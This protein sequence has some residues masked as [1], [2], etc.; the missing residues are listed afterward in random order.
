MRRPAP[1]ENG[2]A[3][4]QGFIGNGQ[5]GPF[6]G[7]SPRPVGLLQ[8]WDAGDDDKPISPRGWLLGNVFC[9]RYVSS[10]IAAGGIGK[11]AVRIAQLLSLASGRSLTGEHVFQQC[12]VLVISLE[13]DPDELRRRVRAAM[14]HHNVTREEVRG[15]LFL[16]A[17]GGNTGKISGKGGEAEKPEKTGLAKELRDTIRRRRIDVVSLD[18]FI[19]AHGEDENNNN[20][21]DGVLT[22]LASCAAELNCS[23]DV[24]HH[25]AKGISD[26]GNADRGRGA[27]AMKDGARLVYTLNVMTEEEAKTF[28]VPEEERRSLVRMDSGKV[29]IAPPLK[30]AK[31][32]R[33][34]GVSLGNPSELYPHGDEVQTV[35]PWVAPDAWE[36]LSNTVLN[37]ILSDIDKGLPDGNRYTDQRN[38]GDRAAWAL[39]AK[40]AP[41]KNETQAKEVIRTWVRNGVLVSSQYQNTATRKPAYGLNV[42]ASKRPTD[43][44]RQFQ[45]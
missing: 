12:R 40:H 45:N 42:N 26:P 8:E 20:A 1:E 32:F 41:T 3:V 36:G 28:N 4:D 35:E 9:R 30:S 37:A 7:T 10:I 24:P 43:A 16:S 11:T 44:L 5:S 19:K 33:I 31:W 25:V 22:I 15:W 17:P 2:H 38:A 14:I 21:I 39:V 18:P 34:V 23:V 13:D 6:N 27:S 29:N